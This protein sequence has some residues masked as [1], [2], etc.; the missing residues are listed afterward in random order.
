[1]K[2]FSTRG[3]NE[4]L[5][6]E[7]TVLTGLAPDGGLYIPETIPQLPENWQTEW[8]NHSF[9]ELSVEVLS[10]Y[11]SRD[12]ISKAQLRALVEK[13]Y[14]T[15]RHPD[16][17]PLRKLNNKV[18]VLELFH[19]PT[20][21][22]K[23]VALQLLGNL[24]EFFLTR[25]NA[26]KA[27]YEKQESLTVVGA[28][29]G[30]TGSAAI[31]GL[32][33]KAD[34]SIFILHP[35]GRVSPIQEAQMTTVT[36]SNVHN[37]AVKGTFDDCQDIVK[38]LFAD[39]E[40]NA[41][42]HLG[43]INSINWARILAQTVY[44]FLSYFHLRRQLSST[45][46]PSELA[47]VKIQY[48]VPT[49][50]FGDILAGYYAKRM[51]LPMGQLVVAT[52]S[53]DILARFWKSGAYEKVDSSTPPVGASAPAAGSSDGAQTHIGGVKETLSPAMDILVSSNFERLL[54]YL[55]FEGLEKSHSATRREAS[56]TVNTWMHSVKQDG[57]VQVPIK[58]LELARRDFVAE[59]TSDEQTLET[60]RSYFLG[61]PSYVVDPHTAVG[62]H[63]AEVVAGQNDASTVQVVLSTAH[64][65]K[66]SEAVT[67]ALE[68]AAG[69]DFE[70]DVLPVEFRGLLEKERRVID[71]EA[72]KIELVK[73]V[74]E[75]FAINVEPPAA[76]PSV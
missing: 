56:K 61:D 5:S 28:T 54:W 52:N 19:G 60:I 3:G 68:G 8:A 12:E 2:Y 40:F 24:F 26:K 1:M 34:I 30:D 46:Q 17:T 73:K 18:F 65:A 64:P 50:N 16:V 11:I 6:F 31:Y 74:I 70:K 29:S 21:A 63:A 53:N 20:F 45:L 59:R 39:R 9:V 23:D 32:R 41:T 76:A 48:V 27:A 38:A 58:V 44:Y 13:S 15:F 36:D 67:R 71:V 55:A 69:F 49:G 14:S 75:Q 57:R 47:D 7:E 66:F 62:L 72:P 51:G 22:F 35:K 10:L 25:R 37:L 33:N 4:L 42:H 43:A